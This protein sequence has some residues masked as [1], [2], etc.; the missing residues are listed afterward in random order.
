MIFSADG[1]AVVTAEAGVTATAMAIQ[2]QLMISHLLQTFISMRMTAVAANGLLDSA[3]PRLLLMLAIT[4]IAA[5]AVAVV[6]TCPHHT[7][8]AV[9]NL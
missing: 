4:L 8:R 3:E 9:T 5:V 6:K 2:Q 7:I 1:V